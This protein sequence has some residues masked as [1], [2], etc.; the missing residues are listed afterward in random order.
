M[1]DPIIIEGVLDRFE[2]KLA[3]IKTKTGSEIFWPIKDLPDDIATG[4]TL[5]L[6][7]TINKDDKEER[8]VLAKS[9]LNEILNVP[10]KTNSD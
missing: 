8:V 10:K 6:T 1:A 4:S 2:E 5:Y 7:L 3:V 9:M